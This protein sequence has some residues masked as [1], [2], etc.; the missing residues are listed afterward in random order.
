MQRAKA[1]RKEGIR[2]IMVFDGGN[3]PAKHKENHD[4][5][6][7]REDYLKKARMVSLGA[8]QP[9]LN[10][11]RLIPTRSWGSPSYSMK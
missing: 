1:L 5:S 6:I 8:N 10:A 4:R 7:Q 9:I 2:V 11:V 3:L